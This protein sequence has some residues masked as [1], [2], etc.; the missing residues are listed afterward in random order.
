MPEFV[1]DYR[2]NGSARRYV[3]IKY[4]ARQENLQVDVLVFVASHIVKAGVICFD[5]V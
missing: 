4:P 1:L 3:K 2:F 5:I